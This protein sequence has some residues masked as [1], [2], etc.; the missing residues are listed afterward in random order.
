[1][2]LVGSTAPQPLFGITRLT[3]LMDGVLGH[4][5]ILALA[6]SGH[7]YWEGSQETE[8]QPWWDKRGG[9]GTWAGR[10]L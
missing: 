8:L 9:A 6:P 5:G 7:M 3:P 1:M 2:E 4:F 10:C